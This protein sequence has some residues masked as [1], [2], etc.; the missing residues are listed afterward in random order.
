[1]GRGVRELAHPA[2]VETAVYG[3]N[4]VPH[5]AHHASCDSLNWILAMRDC[6]GDLSWFEFAWSRPGRTGIVSVRCAAEPES[7]E[8]FAV[9]LKP[10]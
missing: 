6:G 9:P 3:L 5:A 4:G 7:T 1:M 8:G 10:I 2:G